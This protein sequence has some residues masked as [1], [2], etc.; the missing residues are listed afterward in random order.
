VKLE[1]SSVPPAEPDAREFASMV[2][3]SIRG[4]RQER[5]WT[6]VDLAEAANLSPNDVARLE[7]GELGPSFF[8]AHQIAEALGIPVEDLMISPARAMRSGRR[9]AL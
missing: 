8:V 4:A 6:Q 9:R 2:G 1:R 5:G 7:R 3:A